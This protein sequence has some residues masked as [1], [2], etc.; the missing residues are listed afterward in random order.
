MIGLSDMNVGRKCI[1]DRRSGRSADVTRVRSAARRRLLA[2]LPSRTAQQTWCG[3]RGSGI[4][5]RTARSS[6]GPLR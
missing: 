1:S 4:D 6:P 3:A 2:G 5:Y